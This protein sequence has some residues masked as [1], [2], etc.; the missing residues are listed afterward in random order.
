MRWH[1]T[2]LGLVVR[3][4]ENPAQTWAASL[5]PTPITVVAADGS[6]IYPDPHFESCC[7]L[8]N[9]SRIAFQ[10]GTEEAPVMEACATVRR[11][12]YLV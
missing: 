1:L 11:R 5:R 7:C 8:I 6:Q 9:G 10:Y 4:M 12:D 3:P 2:S